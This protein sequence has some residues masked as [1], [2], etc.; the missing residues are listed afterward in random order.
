MSV[1]TSRQFRSGL[2]TNLFFLFA[3]V[4]ETI[5]DLSGWQINELESSDLML[6]SFVPA[7]TPCIRFGP[8]K[9][10]LS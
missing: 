6:F 2:A 5:A 7:A 8:F 1:Q 4:I 10:F 9:D 3:Y